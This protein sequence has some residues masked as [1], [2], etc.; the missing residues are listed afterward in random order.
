MQFAYY[1]EMPLFI[2]TVN[3]TVSGF[4]VCVCV[5]VFSTSKEQFSKYA[6]CAIRETE[7]NNNNNKTLYNLR[8]VAAYGWLVS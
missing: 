6:G 7:N 2:I 8:N 5:V 3:V 1:I 4:C